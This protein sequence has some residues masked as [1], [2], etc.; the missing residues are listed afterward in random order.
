MLT[1]LINGIEYVPKVALPT[2]NPKICD[3]GAQAGIINSRSAKAYWYRRYKC[4]CCG[5]RWTTM[6]TRTHDQPQGDSQ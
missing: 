3:C 2:L 6:E 5:A 4:L 1:V